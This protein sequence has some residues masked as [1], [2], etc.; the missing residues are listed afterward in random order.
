MPKPRA[1]TLG[2]R[3][4]EWAFLLSVALLQPSC[5]TSFYAD[6]VPLGAPAR[7]LDPSLATM[8]FDARVPALEAALVSLET[9]PLAPPRTREL[10]RETLMAFEP[11]DLE[12]DARYAI[13][14]LG[15]QPSDVRLVVVGAHGE[16]IAHDVGLG[17][18]AWVSFRAP[19]TERAL[20]RLYAPDGA[21]RVA[22]L[23]HRLGAL[24]V[25]PSPA[26]RAP[27]P[28]GMAEQRGLL[29]AEMRARG[30]APFEAPRQSRG[31]HRHEVEVPP[32]TCLPY[33]L[34]SEDPGLARSAS[35]EVRIRWPIWDVAC[36]RGGEPTPIEVDADAERE[37][38]VAL[39]RRAISLRYPV[40]GA[41]CSG[42]SRRH[43]TPMDATA[44]LR[45]LG[46]EPLDVIAIEEH[47]CTGRI[48]TLNGGTCYAFFGSA[49]TDIL[50]VD[51]P[52]PDR[53]VIDPA[54]AEGTFTTRCPSTD[55]S[56]RVVLR[57]RRDGSLEQGLV[58]VFRLG[59]P[60]LEA[61]VADV[62]P[63]STMPWA[64][65]A[66]LAL[67][68]YLEVPASPSRS[69]LEA[70]I[71]LEAGAC[72]ALTSEATG[73]IEGSARLGNWSVRAAAEG[74]FSL[75]F[76]A[77]R[78]GRATMTLAIDG[79]P[80]M[81]QAHVLR[82]PGVR[83]CTLDGPR[84]RHVATPAWVGREALP[85]MQLL[86]ARTFVDRCATTL[87][88]L[89]SSYASYT[90]ERASSSGVRGVT[91]I[92]GIEECAMAARRAREEWPPLDEL[93]R[94]AER[95]A[96]AGQSLAPLI[97]ELDRYY[98]QERDRDDGGA[99]GRELHP[100]LV[101]RFEAGLCATE[102]LVRDRDALVLAAYR[103]LHQELV[104][105]QQLAAALRVQALVVAHDLAAQAYG[106]YVG[107]AAASVARYQALERELDIAVQSVLAQR[108]DD[109]S[110]TTPLEHV[111]QPML[112]AALRVS[113]TLGDRRAIGPAL[114][115]LDEAV[116]A[117]ERAL[118]DCR[119]FRP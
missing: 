41:R 39:Y 64:E 60:P 38:V 6:T 18:D 109:C 117:Y 83:S 53:R 47:P 12:A 69:A 2:S 70:S 33:V 7:G 104:A 113:R 88:T 3:S 100:I 105:A 77:P 66:L 32:G 95:M 55:E 21:G 23:R 75:R 107:D 116:R 17:P 58:H 51:E 20:I 118:S 34:A 9:T 111:A 98:A 48:V 79:A 35:R 28:V 54:V 73:R 76:C 81:A 16:P 61:L 57:E 90:Q 110:G 42:P 29:D 115:A 14:A 89:R 96:W 36:A 103:Q 26:L 44:L 24:E 30:Y 84:P 112:A 62:P 1:F 8:P 4:R 46:Y 31:P 87:D 27:R 49:Q 94:H 102:D 108:F 86:R 93:E 85:R 78:G 101:G 97:E 68:G 67:E 63:P 40:C 72:Y 19:R 56:V 59:A 71:E 25:D 15:D 65:A 80:S 10:T 45:P 22:L 43:A 82:R 92:G 74:P 50:A 91:R 106:L 13:L 52:V 11:I 114:V 99:R 5:G 37:T 119:I